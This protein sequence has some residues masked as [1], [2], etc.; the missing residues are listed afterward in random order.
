LEERNSELSQSLEKAES[1]SKEFDTLNESVA[2]LRAKLEETEANLA[3]A[4]ERI[5]AD[6]DAVKEWESKCIVCPLMV[7][8]LDGKYLNSC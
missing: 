1:Q 2:P 6:E 4:N 5:Q 7:F 8:L 3:E